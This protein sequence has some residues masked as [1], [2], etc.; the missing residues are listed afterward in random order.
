MNFA[1]FKC[2]KQIVRGAENPLG[3]SETCECGAD[4]RVCLNCKHYDKNAHR[5]C[6][7]NI[8]EAVREKDR[9][10]F[11][12]SFQ[13]KEGGSALFPGALGDSKTGAPTKSDLMK[14][15]EALFKKK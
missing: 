14:A 13:A 1:C 4:L 7:E 6:R 5:E 8:P 15:A 2:G 3:R 12:D 10:N 9:G 11:C